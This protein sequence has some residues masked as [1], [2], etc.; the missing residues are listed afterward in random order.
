M[1][2][3]LSTWL[4]HKRL[5]SQLKR[6]EADWVGLQRTRTSTSAAYLKACAG[7]AEDFETYKRRAESAYAYTET[8][9]TTLPLKGCVCIRCKL[10]R[11]GGATERGLDGRS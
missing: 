8:D 6:Y 11:R 7:S 10:A 4:R 5:L 3:A 1:R 9:G 2:V